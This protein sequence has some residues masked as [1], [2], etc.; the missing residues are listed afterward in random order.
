MIKVKMQILKATN[1]GIITVVNKKKP[2][3]TISEEACKNLVKN[4]DEASAVSIG[5]V[6]IGIVEKLEYDEESKSVYATMEL[7]LQAIAGFEK[8][9]VKFLDTPSG[10]RVVGGKLVT[11]DLQ[12]N[13]EIADKKTKKTKKGKKKW[14][15]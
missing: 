3:V 12:L 14:T 11:V 7:Y 10:R 13:G 9:S 6:P 15:Q 1:Q 8:D 4:F 5:S 2:E